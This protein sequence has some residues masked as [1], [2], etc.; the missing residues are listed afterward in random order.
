MVLNVATRGVEGRIRAY[1]DPAVRTMLDL[2][3]RAMYSQLPINDADK[4]GTFLV[5]RLRYERT[6]NQLQ[7]VAASSSTVVSARR[8]GRCANESKYASAISSPLMS[9][10]R[11]VEERIELVIGD[12]LSVVKRPDSWV[13]QRD[14]S[15]TPLA[16]KLPLFDS[17]ERPW[18]RDAVRAPGVTW[19]DDIRTFDNIRIAHCLIR[20]APVCSTRPS[21]F[22]SGL[23]LVHIFTACRQIWAKARIK[24]SAS[25]SIWSRWKVIGATSCNEFKFCGG[26]NDCTSRNY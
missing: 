25:T 1:F 22:L 11:K 6:L 4:L 18:Y 19:L 13:V 10:Q 21:T 8:Y 15:R 23:N 7:Y 24:L 17:R 12:T 26:L 5:D 20:I 14:G 16:F 9:V 2:Q 3:Q